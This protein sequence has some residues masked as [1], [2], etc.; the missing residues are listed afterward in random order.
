VPEPPPARRGRSRVLPYAPMGESS[1]PGQFARA[2]LGLNGGPTDPLVVG[3]AGR[4]GKQARTE[5]IAVHVIEVDWM[6]DLADVVPGSQQRASEVLDRAEAQAERSGLTLKTTLLQARDVGA[7]IV[8]EAAAV[9]ADLIVLGLPYRTKFGGDF[10][11]GRVV[12]YVL[13]NAPMAVLV[14]RSPIPSEPGTSS[15]ERR[16]TAGA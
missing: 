5:V 6:H 9:G 12:P 11:M 13:Q 7:A 2:V 1:G 16:A 4:L 3:A 15:T 8:D 10:A 14:V